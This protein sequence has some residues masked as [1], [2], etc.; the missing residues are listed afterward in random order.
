[1]PLMENVQALAALRHK[2]IEVADHWG[3]PV[4]LINEAD[5]RAD[6]RAFSP[7]GV[8][9]SQ[10]NDFERQVKLETIQPTRTT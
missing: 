8:L 4:L 1:M 7:Y 5:P 10:A 6:A 9:I 2:L 3:E